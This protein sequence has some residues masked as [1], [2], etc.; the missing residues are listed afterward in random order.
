MRCVTVG[1]QMVVLRFVHLIQVEHVGVGR[2]LVNIE[3]QAAG[4][5]AHRPLGVPQAGLLELLRKSRFDLD[6]HEDGVHGWSLLSFRGAVKRLVK[7]ES[8]LGV[9]P[10]SG[11]PL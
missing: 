7:A 11:W 3:P 4:L 5:I 8:C 1:G 10:L 9:K 6:G 2:A